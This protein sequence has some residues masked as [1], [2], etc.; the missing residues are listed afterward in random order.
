MLNVF[1]Y[2]NDI[3]FL[4]FVEIVF[5]V[6]LLFLTSFLIIL[7]RSDPFF[8]YFL[9]VYCIYFFSLFFKT[10]ATFKPLYLFSNKFRVT[11]S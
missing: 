5:A 1:T 4:N 10:P 3:Q 2:I 6:Y 9:S 11:C 8:E 7:K